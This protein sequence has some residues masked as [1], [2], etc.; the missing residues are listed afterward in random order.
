M[1]A[2]CARLV[3]LRVLRSGGMAIGILDQQRCCM[4]I[5]GSSTAVTKQLANDWTNWKIRLNY[6]AVIPS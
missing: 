6:I 4:R 1:N 2:S 5:V 3:R